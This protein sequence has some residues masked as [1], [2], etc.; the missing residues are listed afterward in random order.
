MSQYFPHLHCWAHWGRSSSK[1]ITPR[2]GSLS[3]RHNST[4]LLKVWNIQVRLLEAPLSPWTKYSSSS[5]SAFE[6]SSCT[7]QML[8]ALLQSSTATMSCLLMYCSGKLKKLSLSESHLF[9]I[10]LL[11]CLLARG[12]FPQN[13]SDIGTNE[14]LSYR[15]SSLFS[16][17][18]FWLACWM[19]KL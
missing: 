7:T 15:E 9:K 16:S 4:R 13:G 10:G 19:Y 1:Y 18:D 3:K 11:L 14:F 2:L 12:A 17:R 8:T 6:R 5:V